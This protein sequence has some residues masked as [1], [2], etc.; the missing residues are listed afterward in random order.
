M[1][2]S[3][4]IGHIRDF[5]LL[6]VS[7]NI[8]PFFY[9]SLPTFFYPFQEC[10]FMSSSAILQLSCPD[11]KGLVAAVTKFLTDHNGN[12]LSLN[13]YVDR[14]EQRFFMR[15]QWDVQDFALD[16]RATDQQFKSTIADPNQ[17][18]YTLSYT[19]ER[20]RMAI[21]VS[22]LGHCLFDLLGRWQSGEWQVDI[23]LIISNHEEFYEI[24]ANFNIPFHFMP[25]SKQ[26][27]S[28]VEKE[29]LTLLAQNKID[30]VV[31]ARYMQILSGDFVDKYPQKIINIHHSFLPAFPGAKPYHSARQRGVKIIGATSHYVTS[32]LDAGPIVTQDVTPVSHRD[33]VEDMV[34]KGR[35]L[36]KIVLAKAVWYHLQRRIIVH[37]N[38]TVLFD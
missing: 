25:V 28:A 13:E 12:I 30:L 2:K 36:E 14:E 27:K 34:R 16:R 29:Q 19:D 9:H 32:D 20:L 3:R 7:H 38:R 6:S 35:D 24:A 8:T 33:E 37:Q 21:F 4:D 31:L 22:H 23:P 10:V 15:I 5:F 26:N 18:Q 1:L 17:M 11:K